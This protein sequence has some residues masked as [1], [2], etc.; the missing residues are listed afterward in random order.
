MDPVIATDRSAVRSIR[1]SLVERAHAS[2]AKAFETLLLGRLDGLLRTACAIL[3]NEADAR[4]A[5]QEACLSAW[6][7]LPRLRDVEA[8]D[9]WLDRVLVNACRIALRRRGRVREVAMTADHDVPT[10]GDRG[11]SSVEDEELISRAFERLSPDGRAILV[12]HHLRHEPLSVIA[13]ALG[14]PVGTVKSRL[15][16]A[17]TALAEALVGEGR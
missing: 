14:V 8:F 17:R 11:P 3:G 5:T 2:D 16:A 12:L 7:Q 10:A 13:D 1:A 9:G 4:D 6:R 15:N